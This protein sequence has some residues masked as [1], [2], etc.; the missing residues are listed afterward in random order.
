MRAEEILADYEI[1]KL[2][3]NENVKQFDCGDEDINDFIVNDAP[4]YRK[5]LL[6]MTYILKHKDTNREMKIK[7]HD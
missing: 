6:A 7:T 2:G 5:T 4:L 1:R 3:L